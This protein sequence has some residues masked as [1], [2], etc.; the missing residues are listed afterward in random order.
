MQGHG[1]GLHHPR[2]RKDGACDRR[3][4]VLPSRAS[5]ED[6]QPYH[7]GRAIHDGSAL[8]LRRWGAMVFHE[9]ETIL[10]CHNHR[11]EVTEVVLYEGTHNGRHP[12]KDGG[13]V[14]GGHV[15]RHLRT[16]EGNVNE[17]EVCHDRHNGGG[18]V[19]E[20]DVR[21]DRHDDGGNGSEGEGEVCHD[22]RNDG[23]NGSEGGICHGRH[24]V[25]GSVSEDGVCHGH[26]SKESVT[27]ADTCRRRA[28]SN[29]GRKGDQG[30]PYRKQDHDGGESAK[31]DGA[32]HAENSA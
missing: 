10:V 4:L 23:G 17:G 13:S 26:H 28:E 29:G 25:A 8:L 31:G 5:S 7:D 27:G 2:R 9:F 18:I 12:H 32:G 11:D 15:H 20:C 24:N 16:D 21:R 1:E 3:A 14:T 22:R 30:D 6:D 19:S